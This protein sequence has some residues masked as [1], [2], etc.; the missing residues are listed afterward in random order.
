LVGIGSNH[1]AVEAGIVSLNLREPPPPLLLQ[2]DSFE[3]CFWVSRKLM[4]MRHSN[5]RR[6]QSEKGGEGGRDGEN[7]RGRKIL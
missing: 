5:V 1:E 6:R 4:K 7:K 3:G 2:M